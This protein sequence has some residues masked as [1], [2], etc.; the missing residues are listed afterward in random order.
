MI[1]DNKR[2][3]ISVQLLIK[4]NLTERLKELIGSWKLKLIVIGLCKAKYKEIKDIIT[5]IPCNL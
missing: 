4:L 2:H 5:Q 1:T 3:E